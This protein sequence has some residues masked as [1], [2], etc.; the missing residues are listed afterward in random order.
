MRNTFL[1]SVRKKNISLKEKHLLVLR[2][3]KINK[4]SRKKIWLAAIFL[5]YREWKPLKSPKFPKKCPDYIFFKVLGKIAVIWNKP[6]KIQ[7]L[8]LSVIFSMIMLRFWQLKWILDILKTKSTVYNIPPYYFD[9]Q[10]QV[11]S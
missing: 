11:Y 2:Q 3:K 9:I 5:S 1:C 6:L 8:P 7:I 4:S 10:G